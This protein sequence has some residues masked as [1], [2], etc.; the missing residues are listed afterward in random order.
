M[1]TSRFSLESLPW[2][3]VFRAGACAELGT[4]LQRLS[5]GHT[6]LIVTPG[7]KAQAN[8][9][10]SMLG[11]RCAG[12]FDQARPHV[13]EEALAAAIE[14]SDHCGADCCVSIGGGSTTGLGKALALRIGLP[15]IAIPTSYAGSEMTNIWGITD[16]RS[17]VTGRDDTVLPD[18]VIYDPE[19]SVGLPP[20]VSASSG[21]NAIAQAAVNIV[22]PEANPFASA[23]AQAAVRHLVAALPAVVAYAGN[24]ESRAKALCGASLA[25]AALGI[26]LTSLHHRLCHIIGGR[27]DTNHADTHAILLPHSIAYNAPAAANEARNLA[28]LLGANDV[29]IGL[30]DFARHIGAPQQLSALGIGHADIETIVDGVLETQFRNPRPLQRAAL[31]AMLQRAFDGEPPA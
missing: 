10:A 23:L 21:M 3:V 29:G 13:P 1:S 25:G 16:G 7:H 24:I 11:E 9:I 28:T 8:D 30:Y 20:E 26:G 19:L 4:Q 31:Q 18:L 22:D 12:I 27:F 15:N 17:K 5:L 6:L 14:V 2:N